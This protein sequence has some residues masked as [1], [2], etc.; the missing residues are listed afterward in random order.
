MLLSTPAVA[1]PPTGPDAVVSVAWAPKSPATAPPARTH[2]AMAFDPAHG[3]FVLFGGYSGTQVLADTWTWDGTAWTAMSPPS[4]PPPLE[5]AAM[6]YDG[7]GHR[8]LLVGGKG[9]DGQAT[10][11]TW[12]W[13]GTSWAALS[14]AASPTPRYGAAVAPEAANGTLLL[15]GGLSSPTTALND[16]WTWNGTNWQAATPANSPPPRGLAATTLDAA[17]GVVVLFGGT[18]GGLPLG[19]TWTWDGADW[20]KR[21]STTVPWPR[22][23][24][25]MAYDPVTQRA[26][27]FGGLGAVLPFGD[28]WLWDGSTWSLSGLGVFGPPAR[29]GGSLAGAPASGTPRLVLF[30]GLADKALGDTWSLSAAPASPAP[31][32]TGST[33]ST[34]PPT[35]GRGSPSTPPATGKSSGPPKSTPGVTTA[36]PAGPARSAPLAVTAHTIQRGG[37]LTLS[38]TGFAP[39]AKVEII[40]HSATTFRTDARTDGGGTFHQ[41]LEV[42][43]TV[44]PGAHQIEARGPAMGGGTALTLIASIRITAP[45]ARHSWVLPVSMVLLTILVGGAAGAVLIASARWQRSSASSGG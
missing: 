1:A 39:N 44:S 16:T 15:F 38:G 42:P 30:G 14:P 9:S 6:V 45:G 2:A 4:S 27:L 41:T 18:S 11:G 20:T 26:I 32:P 23:D 22:G 12:S 35:T 28:T 29:S 13:D 3:T 8:L 21:N 7:A 17:R 24:A 10:N 25:A 33:P 19:D 40:L 43:S 31:P 5:S 34:A 37:L 36:P